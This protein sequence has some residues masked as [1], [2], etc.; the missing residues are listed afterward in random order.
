MYNRKRQRRQAA[1]IVVESLWNNNSNN[2]TSGTKTGSNSARKSTAKP[3]PVLNIPPKGI[4][5]IADPNVNDVLCGRGGRI[6][7]HAGNVQFRDIIHSK[8]KAYLA[9][10]TKKLEKAHIAAA[11]VNDIRTMN[12]P[13][14]FLKEEKGTGMWYDIGDA[15][16]I[17]KTGQALREDAPDIRPAIDG[18]GGS[19]GDEKKTGM[20]KS[21]AKTN[22]IPPSVSISPRVSQPR[23]GSNETQR[24][25]TLIPILP[26]QYS[27][28]AT[29]HQSPDYR[30]QMSMPP[31]FNNTNALSSQQQ[32]MQ[33][34][35]SQ[36]Q[37][38]FQ[39]PLQVPV[40]A[41]N[42]FPN[43]TYSGGHSGS[44]KFGSASRKAMEALSQAGPT[45]QQQDASYGR[46]PVEDF[47]NFYDPNNPRHM[48][49]DITISTISGL[50]EPL[51]SIKSGRPSGTSDMMGSGR[52]S[53]GMS[54]LM[55]MSLKSNF[56]L[57]DSLRLGSSL[58][59]GSRHQKTYDQIMHGS[60]KSG[61]NKSFDPMASVFNG[62]FRSL[63]GSMHR[64]NSF[65]DNMNS[66]SF[67]YDG[68]NRSSAMSIGSIM[69][70]QSDASST[71]WF[72]AAL[73][74]LPNPDEKSFASSAIMSSDLDALDLA[75]TF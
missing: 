13:G 9:P 22:D 64:S 62:S 55:N 7:S 49:D 17:K 15:K 11:I 59:S 37:H 4:G 47:Q 34:Q 32:F 33:H 66:D 52:P 18:E 26:Q 28:N 1:A 46:H 54:D 3:R 19:S 61:S 63:G 25:Q 56:S 65:P 5:P 41:S 69:D 36:H 27:T 42:S 10:T 70:L 23:R 8:K 20:V 57:T 68:D 21:Q 60:F 12:P 67:R 6:N 74:N 2:D 31:P 30:G 53:S 35:S 14:R 73:G 39:V 29:Q 51:S 45:M 44:N 72:Q 58:K 75:S 71:Q 48:S 43:Q 16:A 40:G 38:S 50:S 24:T